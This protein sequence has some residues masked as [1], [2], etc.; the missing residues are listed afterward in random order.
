MGQ[1]CPL[2][3]WDPGPASPSMVMSWAVSSMDTGDTTEPPPNL[4]GLFGGVPWSFTSSVKATFLAIR[5]LSRFFS[6][7]S[8]GGEGT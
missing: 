4:P 1:V 8:W 3:T 7:A 5:T 2:L 6:P